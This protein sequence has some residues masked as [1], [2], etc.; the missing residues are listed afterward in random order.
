MYSPLNRSKFIYL[1]QLNFFL[2]LSINFLK[3]HTLILIIIQ[4]LHSRNYL[5]CHYLK[6][7]I[8]LCFIQL[9]FLLKKKTRIQRICL[10]RF[11]HFPIQLTTKIEHL[12]KFVI[13]RAQERLNAKLLASSSWLSQRK[14]CETKRML[15][16]MKDER[17]C[18]LKDSQHEIYEFGLF[19]N[20][21]Y[22]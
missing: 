7:I 19:F 8:F 14:I 22:L 3:Y 9:Q 20:L 17:S 5:L 15:K 11:F 18:S 10:H 12:T 1:R 6:Y 16:V 4:K 2:L 21:S 13:E